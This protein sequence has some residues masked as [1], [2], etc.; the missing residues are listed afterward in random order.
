MTTPNASSPKL[1]T[2]AAEVRAEVA[3]VSRCVRELGQALAVID[4]GRDTS[5]TAVPPLS[6]YGAAALLDTLY[7]G[8]EKALRR[9]ANVFGGA[10]A[11]HA[12]HRELLEQSTLDIPQVRPAVLDGATGRALDE[13]LAFRHRFRNLYLFELDTSLVAGL[14]ERAPAAAALAQSDLLHFAEVLDRAADHL[15]AEG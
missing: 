7:T 1:R 5:D 6:L 3:R 8:I 14:M 10:P 2:L 9:I 4:A 15:D 11:G 12:W 13:L